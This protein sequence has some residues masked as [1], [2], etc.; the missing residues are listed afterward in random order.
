LNPLSAIDWLGPNDI[1]DSKTIVWRS[2]DRRAG[3][4]QKSWE[5]PHP[6]KTTSTIDFVSANAQSAPF[7]VGI[8][9]H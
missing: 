5:N 9:L 6:D 7:L 1:E 3:L 2:V 4:S 8:T